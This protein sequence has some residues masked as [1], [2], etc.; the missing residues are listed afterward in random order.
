VLSAKGMVSR[1]DF[2]DA[3][4]LTLIGV[5]WLAVP[6][7]LDLSSFQQSII[8]SLVIMPLVLLFSAIWCFVIRNRLG[9]TES[10]E[11]VETR[12]KGGIFF[13]AFVAY[14]FSLVEDAP[15]Y[16]DSIFTWPEVTSGA[17]HVLL[18]V[19]LHLLTFLFIFLTLRE[20]RGGRPDTGDRLLL[21]FLLTI[22]A[23][24]SSYA[25]NLPLEVVREVV[26][27]NFYAL[28]LA[29]HLAS[30]VLLWLAVSYLGRLTR[31]PAS[32]ESPSLM[33]NILSDSD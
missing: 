28:D 9:R 8:A 19:I 25:Q 3:T 11:L 23:F 31:E 6:A 16:L 13:F 5:P 7:Y 22:P 27:R 2:I 14:F 10:A 17:Q 12:R 29:E 4:V 30:V 18:E 21:T 24:V 26:E 33:K 15:V 32:G 20:A 1:M